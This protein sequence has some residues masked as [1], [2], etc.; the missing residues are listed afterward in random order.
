MGVFLANVELAHE[1][2]A[3]P[4]QTAELLSSQG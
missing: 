4:G 3:D 2:G 1:T